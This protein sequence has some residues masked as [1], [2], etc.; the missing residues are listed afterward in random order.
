MEWRVIY[1]HAASLVTVHQWKTG[2]ELSSAS[3]VTESVAWV[4]RDTRKSIKLYWHR[5]RRLEN[6]NKH[7]Q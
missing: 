1:K 3:V 2:K 6:R 4:R 5:K 7:R